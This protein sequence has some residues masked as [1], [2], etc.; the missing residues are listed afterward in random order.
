MLA[1]RRAYSDAVR[2]ARAS[3]RNKLPPAAFARGAFLH[4]L[5]LGVLLMASFG[6]M[7]PKSFGSP[8]SRALGSGWGTL[9]MVVVLVAAVLHFAVRRR[10]LVRLWDLVRGTLRGAPADEGYEG[11]MN[12]LSSCPGPL[13]ARFAIMWVWLPLAVGAIAMLLACSAGYFFVDAVLARFDV[14]LG[15]VLYGLSFA[16]A[17]LLVF[18]AV[19]PRLLSWRVAYAANRDATSY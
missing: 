17:S 7:S 14:G 10:R 16:L 9:S 19:A 15:Q 1:A 3:R 6:L 2:W 13:R 8:G 5:M 18:L 4:S 12:A 11:T